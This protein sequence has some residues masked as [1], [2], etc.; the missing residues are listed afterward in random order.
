M[1]WRPSRQRANTHV[2]VLA[3]RIASSLRRQVRDNKVCDPD[4]S[5]L[6]K[7][8][9]SPSLAEADVSFHVTQNSTD[10]AIAS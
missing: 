2:R 7:H 6:D 9:P 8:Q 4:P 5:T 10:E 1:P 3:R